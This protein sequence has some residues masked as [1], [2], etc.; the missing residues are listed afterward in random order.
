MKTHKATAKR[1]KRSGSGFKRGM[2]G[3][4]HGN[5]GWSRQS[6]KHLTGRTEVGP[7]YLKRLRKLLP[8]K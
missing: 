6:L 2:S 4:K 8:Y 7:T 3:R 5:A 1:F